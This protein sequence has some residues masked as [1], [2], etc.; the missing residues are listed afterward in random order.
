MKLLPPPG[1]ER[2]RAIAM[3]AVIL[4]LAAYYVPG[5][6]A[7]DSPPPTAG[8]PTNPSAASSGQSAPLAPAR[9]TSQTKKTDLDTP[10]AVNLAALEPGDTT[11][12][13]SGRNPFRYGEPPKPPAPAYVPPPPQA[14]VPP[15][16]PPPPPPPQV[17]L[18]LVGTILAPGETRYRAS[19][20]DERDMQFSGVEGDV[21]DGRYKVIKVDSKSAVVSFLDGT[22]RR[23]LQVGG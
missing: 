15:P 2:W 14:Y 18:K 12:P 8:R 10:V 11:S 1:P 16:P 7:P 9:G 4:A 13:E 6:F 21:I 20:K 23:T 17:K 3:L 5:V 22:G 19:F